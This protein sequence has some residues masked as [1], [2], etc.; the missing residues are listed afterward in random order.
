MDI[1][2]SYYHE[3]NNPLIDPYPTNIRNIVL[4]ESPITVLQQLGFSDNAAKDLNNYQSIEAF[5]E[6]NNWN[7]F[8]NKEAYNWQEI[9]VQRAGVRSIMLK[10]YIN[11]YY[12]E[13]RFE[14]SPNDLLETVAFNQRPKTIN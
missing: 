8:G 6:E 1:G 11:D 7:A 5:N 14:F 13:I 4:G 9:N 12:K 3:I 2:S 10:Y